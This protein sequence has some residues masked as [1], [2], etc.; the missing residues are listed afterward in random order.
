MNSN[1]FLCHL[2]SILL[3]FLASLAG[4][5]IIPLS[6]YYAYGQGLSSNDNSKVPELP[7]NF[8]MPSEFDSFPSTPPADFFSDLNF[9]DFSDFETPLTTTDDFDS[10]EIYFP[11]VKGTYTNSDIG[12]QVDLPKDWKG[13]EIKFLNNMVFAAPQ[14]INLDKLEEPGTLMIISGIDQKYVDMLTDFTKQFP[15]FEGGE[16][17]SG[18]GGEGEEQGLP[19]GNNPMNMPTPYSN[20]ESCN[21]FQTLP[22]TINGISAEQLMAECIAEKGINIKAKSYAFATQDDSII[23]MAFVSNTTEEYNQYLPLFDKSVKTLKITNPGNIA[24]SD[25]YKKFKELELQSK[26]KTMG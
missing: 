7:P 16:G 26:V 1:L 5:V 13:K 21:K 17:G 3:I 22:V 15:T 8:E 2:N 11:D 24:T 23:S 20:T 19:Q 9:S 25:I 12:F 10:P 6:N 14:E 4:T 18:L